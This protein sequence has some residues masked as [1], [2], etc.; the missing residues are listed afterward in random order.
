VKID[1]VTGT[2]IRAALRVHSQLGPGLLESVYS[3]CLVYA[4]Q[5]S[6]SRVRTQVPITI[7]FDDNRI[8]S[9]VRLDLLVENSVIVEVKAVERLVPL[10]ASQL[11]S[12]LRLSDLRVGLLL[13]FNVRHMRQGIKR[14]VN[15]FEPGSEV[16]PGF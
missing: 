10:H 15:R 4:L 7:G 11:L 14:V 8:E 9:G 6:G 5:A 2:I 3:A 16:D 13:N 12:Y 1:D